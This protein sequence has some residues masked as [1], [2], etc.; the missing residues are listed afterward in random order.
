VVS[1]SIGNLEKDDLKN[2]KKLKVLGI[3]FSIVFYLKKILNKYSNPYPKTKN[4]F[5]ISFFF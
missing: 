3:D 5:S 2:K 1:K 4:I